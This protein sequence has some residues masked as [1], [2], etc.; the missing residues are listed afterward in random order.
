MISTKGRYALRVLV[1]LAEQGDGARARLKDIAKRQGISEK[2]LQQIA[3]VLADC[4]MLDGAS[5]RGGGYKLTGRPEDYIVSDVLEKV[6]G[7]IAPVACLV[8]GAP[9]CDRAPGCKTLPMWRGLYQA[10]L[11]YLGSITI[12]DLAEGAALGE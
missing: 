5:G 2:Y 3:R 4:G 10:E 1:D 7:T 6:E 12:A 11:A 8:P 9:P